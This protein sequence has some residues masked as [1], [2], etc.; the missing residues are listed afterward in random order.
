[1]NLPRSGAQL[2]ASAH[3]R[4]RATPARSTRPAS[5]LT[6]CR[7]SQPRSTA[8]PRSGTPQMANVRARWRATGTLS[9]Q[10]SSRRMAGLCSL[11]LGTAPAS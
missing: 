8:L 4:L 6:A 1:M 3:A 9:F 5:L 10:R 2:T 7:C 11:P